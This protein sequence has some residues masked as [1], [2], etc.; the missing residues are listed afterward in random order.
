MGPW[1]WYLLVADVFGLGVMALCYL[2]FFV[3]DRRRIQV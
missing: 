1:P 2:P 3:L